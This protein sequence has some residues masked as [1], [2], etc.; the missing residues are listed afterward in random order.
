MR[1]ADHGEIPNAFY[2]EE[3][4]NEWILPGEE[5]ARKLLDFI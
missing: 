4:D 2:A 1:R 3:Y 5:N